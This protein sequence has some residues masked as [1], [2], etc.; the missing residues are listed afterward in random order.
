M[1]VSKGHS[2]KLMKKYSISGGSLGPKVKFLKS[3]IKF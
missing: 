1:P 2:V 3:L